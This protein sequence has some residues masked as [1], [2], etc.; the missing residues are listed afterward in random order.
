MAWNWEL[1]G[2]PEFEWN[3]E[4]LRSKEQAFV[5]NAAIPVGSTRLLGPDNRAEL[6]IEGEVLDRD[7]V[8]SSLDPKAD[9]PAKQKVEIQPLFP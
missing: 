7:R 5:E 4:R 1:E 6:A 8:K 2:W 3:P 9:E